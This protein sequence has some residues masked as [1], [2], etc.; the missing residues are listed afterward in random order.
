[1]LL[2]H[3]RIEET[4]HFTDPKNRYIL[5]APNC[6]HQFSTPLL[7]RRR[8]ELIARDDEIPTADAGAA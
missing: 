1:M 4:F 5:E 3:K 6:W 7:A 8:A 2:F